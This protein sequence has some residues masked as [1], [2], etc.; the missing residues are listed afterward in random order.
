MLK[1]RLFIAIVPFIFC[2]AAP[3]VPAPASEEILLLYNERPPYMVSSGSTVTGLS[4]DR[5][6]TIFIKAGIPHRWEKFPS[7]RIMKMIEEGKRPCCAPNWFKTPERGT[8]AKF[9]ISFRRDSP[10]IALARR[11]NA[12]LKTPMTMKQ[13]LSDRRLTLLVKSGYSYGPD[14][15]ALIAKYAPH[16]TDTTLENSDMLRLISQGAAD[17]M[18]IAPEEA[19]MLIANAERPG[20]FMMIRL[21]DAPS[22]NRR[23]LLFSK[24]VDDAVIERI[25]RAI[26]ELGYR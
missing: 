1:L 26:R 4:A 6:N 10:A 16:R 20:D 17:Y 12:G 8:F 11:S 18:F 9:S 14:V 3:A 22:G 15:D 2:C 7:K 19:E 25:N 5:I 24:N 13:L 23:Y 21:T